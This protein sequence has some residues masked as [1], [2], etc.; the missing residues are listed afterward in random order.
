MFFKKIF[1]YV[2]ARGGQRR[3]VDSYGILS[4]R[5]L[6]TRYRGYWEAN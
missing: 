4:Y 5:Q 6:R 1:T 2:G 3:A